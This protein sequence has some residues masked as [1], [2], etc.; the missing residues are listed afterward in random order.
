[1]HSVSDPS[2]RR[3]RL[4]LALILALGLGVRLW[5]IGFGL[6]NE[7]ARPDE[8]HLIGYTLTMGG[9]HLDPGFFNYPSL[10]LYLLLFVYG[11]YFAV[12]RAFGHFHSVSD[13]VREYALAPGTLYLLDRILVALLGTATILCVYAVGTRAVCRRAGLLAAF[14]TSVAYLH[15][16]DSHFGTVDVPLTFFTTL[17]TL[18][19]LGA[20]AEPTPRRF[21]LAGFVAGLAVSTKY[22]AVALLAP[23]VLLH[24]R[25]VP[26]GGARRRA[27][28]VLLTLAAMVGGF[29][30]GTPFSVLNRSKF[31]ADA[32]FELLKKSGERPAIDLGTGW[33]RHLA[34]TLPAGL[35]LPLLA[36]ALVGMVVG[37]RARP[38]LASVLLAFPLAWWAGV[39]MSRYVYARYAVPLVP[40]LCLFAAWALEAGLARAQLRA[41][42]NKRAAAAAGVAIALGVAA[43]SVFRVVEFD[44]L[45]TR[46]DTRVLAAAW[47][48][49]HA[50][51]GASLGFVGPEYLW[52]Q[53]WDAAPQLRRYLGSRDAEHSRG[54]RLRA[55]VRLA[56]ALAGVAPSYETVVW[57]HG[58]WSDTLAVKA[59]AASGSEDE[60]ETAPRPT[61]Q[62]TWQPTWIVLADHPSWVKPPGAEPELGDAYG[63]VAAF[64]GGPGVAQASY[65]LQDAV[66]FPLA[67]FSGVERPG[68]SL[69]VYRL[70]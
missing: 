48:E 37:L 57:D 44:R 42:W 66:Y 15:V 29:V 18:A 54:R 69:R 53:V 16:R 10:Y 12:G 7:A 51:S 49:D 35:G 64:E 9:N 50:P 23:L 65:D 22:N 19:M 14:F 1:M 68:P 32:S 46:P 63:E 4:L 55:E 56:H 5:G 30:V 13:V 11:G 41:A 20:E 47:I 38:R 3:A 24:L 28:D 52:P 34:F 61:G 25:A 70:R 67:G 27:A 21:A 36:A 43:P 40:S 60:R 62:P 6:P 39:G 8:R 59:A 31:L 2:A 58:A 26:A 45:V 17:A 33:I